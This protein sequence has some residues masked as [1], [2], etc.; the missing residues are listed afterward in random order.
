MVV[1]SVCHLYLTFRLYIYIYIFTHIIRITLCAQQKEGKEILFVIKTRRL[2]G[3]NSEKRNR[4]HY[5]G[6]ERGRTKQTFRGFIAETRCSLLR[7]YCG[8]ELVII[9]SNGYTRWWLTRKR[10]LMCYH[11]PRYRA[12]RGGRQAQ[13]VTRPS[14][15]VL[16]RYERN[17]WPFLTTY[18]LV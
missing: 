8:I 9:M 12:H 14:Y 10:A 1:V 5:S 18:K 2:H 4:I 7:T 6:G 11:L 13:C 3:Q 15:V 17:P 16:L